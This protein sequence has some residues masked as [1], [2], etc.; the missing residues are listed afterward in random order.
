MK[1]PSEDLRKLAE[2][3]QKQFKGKVALASDLPLVQKLKTGIG[4]LDI[5]TGGGLPFGRTI[6]IYG[7]E[8]SGKSWISYQLIIQAQKQGIMPVL[9]D[10]ENAFDPVWAKRVG[11]DL[12][13]LIYTVPNSAEQGIDMMTGILEEDVTNLIVLDSIDAI[14]PLAELNNPAESKQMAEKAKLVNKALRVIT[15]RISQSKLDP[16]PMI[17][18]INQLRDAMTLYGSPTTTP[19][20][21]GL[22]YYASLRIELNRGKRKEEN[23]EKYQEVTF[24]I[25]KN[26]VGI[27]YKS[28]GYRLYIEGERAGM[29]D[30]K[31]DMIAEAQIKGILDEGVWITYNGE[32]FQGKNNLV[33]YFNDNPEVY[34][35]FLNKF[36]E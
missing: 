31:E 14:V 16:K 36:Y 19:G 24:K 3:L 13:K 34:Q 28:G 7:K 21:K 12:D 33:K 17:V 22:R 18:F 23:G 20:G 10:A 4:I 29:H 5:K 25:E 15:S 8:S 6:E 11:I 9:I 1:S 27:P 32:K 30:D 35:E 26:K 2:K